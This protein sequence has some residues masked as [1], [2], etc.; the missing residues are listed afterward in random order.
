MTASDVKVAVRAEAVKAVA[1]VVVAKAAV[2]ASNAAM[3]AR[4]AKAGD[5]RGRI[6]AAPRRRPSKGN[7]LVPHR[8]AAAIVVANEAAS[9][10]LTAVPS[11]VPSATVQKPRRARVVAAVKAASNATRVDRAKGVASASRVRRKLMDKPLRW[12]R[13]PHWLPASRSRRLRAIVP[14]V[15]V[16]SAVAVDVATGRNVATGHRAKAAVADVVGAAVAIA[17]TMRRHRPLRVLL[18]MHWRTVRR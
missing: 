15:S 1:R 11:A 8:V 18:R 9:A 10:V 16:A 12:S 17:G 5:N 13:Q 7:R 2:I 3:V 6:A 14:S 4:V